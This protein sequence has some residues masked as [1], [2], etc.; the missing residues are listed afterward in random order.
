MYEIASQP[1]ACASHASPAQHHA[2]SQ[3]CVQGH[4]ANPFVLSCLMETLSTL[5]AQGHQQTPLLCPV[6]WLKLPF[7]CAGTPSKPLNILSHLMETLNFVRREAHSALASAC[8]AERALSYSEASDSI[9]TVA[10][11]QKVGVIVLACVGDCFGM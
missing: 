11:P 2:H 10:Q 8:C 6:S 3:P 5:C 4:P 7:L 1:I 9:L